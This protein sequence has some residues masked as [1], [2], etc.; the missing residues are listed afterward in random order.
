[1]RNVATSVLLLL[2]SAGVVLGQAV[3]LPAPRLLTVTPMGGKRGATVEVAIT[4]NHLE[5][6]EQLVFS[7]PAITAAP[8]LDDAGNPV[9]NQYV[10]AIA[11]NCPVGIHEARL[12]TRRGVSTSRVFTVGTLAEIAV[13]APNQSL[14]TATPIEVNSVANG[15]VASRA[16][17]FYSFQANKGQQ[18]SIFCAAAGIESKLK[19]VLIVADETGADLQVERRGRSIDFT[20]PA[21][22]SYVLKVHD[23]TYSGGPHYFYRLSIQDRAASA[24][25]NEPAQPES[26]RAVSAFSWPP[27]NLTEQSAGAEQEPNNSHAEAQAITLPCD[28]AGAFYPAADVDTFE[29]TAVKGEVWWVEVASHRLGLNT[30]PSIVVQRVDESSG[31]EKLVDVAELNDIPSP[32]K[33]SSNGYSYD[34]PPYNAGSSD[35]LGK[36]EIPENGT[37]RLQI[38]DLFGGARNVPHNIY[39]MVIRKAE[40]DFALVGWALHMNLRNGDRNALSKPIALRPG[41]TMPIEV[42]AIRRD[43]FDGEIELS[44]DNLPQGVSATGLKIAAGAT[45]G[46]VLVTADESAPHGWT[47]ANFQGAAE[48]D[49]QQVTRELHLASMRWPVPDASQEIPSPRLLR[50]TP[51]SVAEVEP[52]PL[53]ISAEPKVFEVTAGEKLTIPLALKRRSEFSGS[54][55]NLKT[56]GCV[57]EKT[58]AFDATLTDDSVEAVIDTAALKTPPGEYT[59]AFYGGAVVKYIPHTADNNAKP[60]DTVDIMVS[61]PVQI[62]VKPAEAK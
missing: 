16:V 32:M 11:E 51:V 50:S 59:I 57:F 36:L 38:R 56:F 45:R 13:A 17:D 33:V 34:G 61:T 29:F 62:R 44:I 40:P 6:P 5:G 48:I 10:V 15:A 24:S 58:P 2:A 26:V 39:R 37:Y 21:D 52:A 49:G 3:C 27:P 46:I 30:D 55:I 53:T 18:L 25:A 22:G 8:K 35:I 41:A 28:L 12:V 9:A 23:L 42:L 1:M 54:T 4:G 43:G 47:N 60:K 31:E 14:E 19:P 20:V 7:T